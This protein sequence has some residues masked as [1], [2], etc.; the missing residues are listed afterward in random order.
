MSAVQYK[1]V[2]DVAQRAIAI[3]RENHHEM[4]TLEH[5]LSALLENEDIKKCFNALSVDIEEMS[6]LMNSFMKAG[7]IPTTTSPDAPSKSQDFEVLFLRVVGIARF[8][9]RRTATALD[10]LL[11]MT[12]LPHEDSY[13]VTALLRAGVNSLNV[14]KYI[15]HGSGQHY[16]S[17]SEFDGMGGQSDAEPSNKEE[18]I[19]YLKKYS[20]DLNQLAKDGKIDPLIGRAEEVDQIVQITARRTKNNCILVGD[21]GVGKTAVVEGLALKIVAGEV[22]EI[23]KDSIIY[24]LDIGSLVAGTRFRGDFEERMKMVL[25]S[26]TYLPDSILF[27][28]EIHTIMDAGS[29]SKGSLD[30]ANLLKPALAKGQLRCIGSTTSEEYRKHIE[31]DRAIVRRFKKVMIDEPSPEVTKVI[32]RGLKASY[33]NFHGVTFTDEAID[34]AVDLTHKYVTTSLLPDK[35]IDIIDNAGAR[36][37]I[38][39][40]ELRKTEIGSHE[41]EQE[42][43][44]ITKIPAKEIAESEETVML[45]LETDLKNAVFGQND[46]IDVLV[47][48]VFI[49]RAGL[50]DI[51]KPAGNYLFIGPTGVGK[52]EMARQLAKSLNIPLVKFDMSEYMEKHSV[53]KFIGAPPGYVGFGEGGAGNGILINAID[54]NPSCVLLLD[55]IE[56]AHDDIFNVLL[57]VM[58]DARLTSSGGKTVNFRNV[59]LIMTSNAGIASFDK[60]PLGFVDSEIAEVDEKAIKNLFRPEFRNRLDSI[61]KFNRLRPENMVRIVDK[62]ITELEDLSASRN[63]KINIQQDA[64]EWLA[65]EGYDPAMGARPLARVINDNIKKPLSRLM[66]LGPL[67][68][69]GGIAMVTLRDGK[70]SVE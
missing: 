34:A 54:T 6:D 46:A 63:V 14:K 66:L 2:S 18:A 48:S 49:A 5:I 33:E 20:A 3:A 25:K 53:S 8:S 23:L 41:I 51:K 22:P 58:D 36:Q 15:A 40:V 31:K 35:A 10:V 11:N 7:F 68:E 32:L 9:S 52:T 44:R 13:A 59:I 1:E 70:L 29:G 67:K 50:R 12:Q 17:R 69:E 30:V 38:L 16:V 65:K 28:D 61:V 62:F 42:V 43:S 55:E 64:R 21:S 45:R 37:R 56:K 27:I 24:A 39:P 19:K 26:L 57:Q 47:D 4:A 60:N